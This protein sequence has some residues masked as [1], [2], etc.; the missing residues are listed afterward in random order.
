MSWFTNPAAGSYGASKAAALALTDSIRIELRAQGTLVIGV[1]AGYIDTDMAASINA[2][3]SRPEDV[4][5]AT[6]DA[7]VA[8]HEEVLA[9]KSSRDIRAALDADRQS[10]NRQMQQVWDSRKMLA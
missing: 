3:K 7:I 6:M 10:L 1:H 9:D 4:A 5:T 2:P 8:G